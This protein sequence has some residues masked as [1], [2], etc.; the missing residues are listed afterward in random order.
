[1]KRFDT[2]DRA[3]FHVALMNTL[4]DHPDWAATAM[5]A[6]ADGIEIAQAHA[7]EDA[8]TARM[9]SERKMLEL[10]YAQYEKNESLFGHWYDRLRVHAG[11]GPEPEFKDVRPAQKRRLKLRRT[12]SAASR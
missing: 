6:V 8:A 7:A 4:A 1:M 5:K 12:E 11:C 2:N 10:A 3:E 9:N